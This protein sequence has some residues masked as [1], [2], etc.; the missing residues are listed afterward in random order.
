M[1]SLLLLPEDWG[2]LVT[3]AAAEMLLIELVVELKAAVTTLPCTQRLCWCLLYE[4]LNEYCII[5]S[6]QVGPRSDYC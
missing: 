3:V 5:G 1:V 6:Y 2:H 4:F